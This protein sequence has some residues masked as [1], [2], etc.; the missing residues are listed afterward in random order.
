M[1]CHYVEFLMFFHVFTLFYS[2]DPFM[3]IFILIVF[4]NQ[5][6]RALSFYTLF[7]WSFSCYLKK[8]LLLY[9]IQWKSDQSLL[10][11]THYS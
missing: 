1:T 2:Y 11:M 10:Q 7:T 4:M 9:L 5:A 6:R 8:L 3:I